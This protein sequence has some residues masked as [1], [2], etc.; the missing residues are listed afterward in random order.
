MDTN[1]SEDFKPASFVSK[2]SLPAKN[3]KAH[4]RYLKKKRNKINNHTDYNEMPEFN[5]ISIAESAT[6]KLSKDYSPKGKKYIID[7]KDIPLTQKTV[8][9]YKRNC[10][11]LSHVRTGDNIDGCI[12]VDKLSVVGFIAVETKNNGQKWIQ[13][14]EVTNLY[15]GYGLSPQLLNLATS[16]Y[17]ATHLSVNENNEIAIR[18][19]EINGFEKYTSSGDMIFMKRFD[20]IRGGGR[21]KK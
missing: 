2:N 7:F 15:R 21:L 1:I 14:L 10:R 8:D 20:L 19:Y 13:A 5:S 16:H 11:S 9:E 18:L 17:G 6:S 4:V 3:Q 12:L